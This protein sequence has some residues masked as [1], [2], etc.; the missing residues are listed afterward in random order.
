MKK[1]I[2][3]I[4]AASILTSLSTSAFGQPAPQVSGADIHKS[5]DALQVSF[6]VSV[7]DVA[8]DSKI[9]LVPVV[10]DN[11]GSMLVME[12]FEL[13]GRRKIISDS[14]AGIDDG[15]TVKT[16]GNSTFRY[17]SS[18]QWGEWMERVS[19]AVYMFCEECGSGSEWPAVTATEDWL[20]YHRIVP[21]FNRGKITFE[22]APDDLPAQSRLLRPSAEYG[23]RLD[24]LTEAADVYAA[25]R[26]R[27]GKYD[28]DE[29][30]LA[31][32][33]AFNEISEAFGLLRD[34]PSARLNKIFI[35]G[36]A[37]PEGS[38]AAN[39]TLAQR[40]AEAVRDYLIRRLDL[41]A[42][43]FDLYNGGENW[44]GL[45][46][47]VASS[48]M[49][50]RDGAL[51]IIDGLD[52]GETRKSRLRHFA[53]GAPY[54]YMDRYL[55]PDLRIAGYIRI[56]Y[57][58]DRGPDVSENAKVGILNSATELM[59]REMWRDALTELEKVAE[60]P[61]AFNPTGV[62]HM[63]LGDYNAA[64]V[65]FVKAQGAGDPY[66]ADNLRQMEAARAATE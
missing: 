3:Y 49:A 25:V 28:V 32:A 20:V 38:L 5:G 11:S 60:D 19:L 48:D 35:A 40:R 33:T 37:S 8:R 24:A 34:K 45:R 41:N 58:V 1:Q 17:A 22:P 62:C 46:A 44:S 30:Y 2:L 4:V 57:E 64:G 10:Y 61:R 23:S 9:T 52:N 14:R 27:V 26:F 7:G 43:D 56:Y 36:Y 39:T 18:A 15:L 6:T 55:F 63:M 47:M 66:A 65:W 50:D 21:A 42:W 12:P 31:N 54:D 51:Q 16:R 53:Q 29:D 13:A 59:E